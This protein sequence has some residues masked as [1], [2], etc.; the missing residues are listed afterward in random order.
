MKNLASACL[1][2]LA[3]GAIPASAADMR[4]PT[5]APPM[6]APPVATWTGC[7]IG[8]NIGGGWAKETYTD[9]LAVFPEPAGLGSHTASGVMGGGQVGC[10]WQMGQWVVGAR[11]MFDASDLTGN[12]LL[13]PDGDVFDTRISWYG[14]ATVRVGYLFTPTLLGYIQG[15]AAFKRQK[16]VIIDVIPEALAN[17]DRTGGT[18]G[19]GA[20]WMFAPNWSVFVEGNWAGFGTKTLTFVD[21]EV[22]PGPPFPLN[23]KESVVTV[24]GGVNFR[25]GWPHP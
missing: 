13:L 15:G 6:A 19:I 17:K 18:V 3:I 24:V 25:F 1:A 9:P 2:I 12:H 16:E 23:I 8:A 22:P 14:T 20:E 4:M 5:K 7:Y 11:G 10:D 21:L